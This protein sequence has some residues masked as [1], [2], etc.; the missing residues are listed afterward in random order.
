VSSS[1]EWFGMEFREFA[2]IFFCGT[3]FRVVFSSAE[4]SERNSEN[5]PFRIKIGIPSEITI[6]SIYSVF[7]GFFFVGNS[8]P[9]LY[10]YCSSDRSG[11]SEIDYGLGL[12]VRLGI[13][14]A[15]VYN[16]SNKR[17]VTVRCLVAIQRN[18]QLVCNTPTIQGPC[19]WHSISI[20]CSI[21]YLQLC[22]LV[23][24]RQRGRK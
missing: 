8:Q 5:F 9:Y 12:R 13:K 17:I 11:S 7:R 18:I 20:H 23:D 24:H 1:A 2:S 10:S 15:V 19:R 6:C 3:E 21:S 14:K 4:G 22:T 16:V